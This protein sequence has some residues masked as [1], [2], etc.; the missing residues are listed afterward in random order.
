MGDGRVIIAVMPAQCPAPS[1]ATGPRMPYWT[2]GSERHDIDAIRWW[3]EVHGLR[4]EVGGP[5]HEA[6]TALE[7]LEANAPIDDREPPL[8]QFIRTKM[9]QALGWSIRA[10]WGRGARP[11]AQVDRSFVKQLLR[12]DLRG[13]FSLPSGV[14][15]LWTAARWHQVGG[16]SLRI[17]GDGV[18]GIDL[19]WKPAELGELTIHAECKDRAVAR[20][21]KEGQAELAQFLKT[22]LIET[23]GLSRP[24]NGLAVVVLGFQTSVVVA[25][26]LQETFQQAV[27]DARPALIAKGCDLSDAVLGQFVGFDCEPALPFVDMSNHGTLLLVARRDAPNPALDVAQ[28]LLEKL[29]G[30]Q[31]R[32]AVLPFASRSDERLSIREDIQPY[33]GMSEADRARAMS[34]LTAWARDV[35]E[36]AEQPARVWGW[37][38]PLAEETIHLLRRLHLERRGDSNR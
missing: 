10:L 6:I 22:K 16:G 19:I 3:I 38:D 30:E 32:D 17:C 33:L 27:K 12:P 37:K 36:E 9:A 23:A 35:A 15:V 7:R 26:Q 20:S 25:R 18:P 13:G 29:Y 34:K 8:H 4:P 5:V 1:P 31:S 11:G 24:S 14:N 2:P 21:L 28:P